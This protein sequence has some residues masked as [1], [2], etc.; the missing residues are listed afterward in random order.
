M[1]AA[2]TSPTTSTTKRAQLTL[3]WQI[4]RAGYRRRVAL[5]FCRLHFAQKTSAHPPTVV[6]TTCRYHSD[7]GVFQAQLLLFP[8]HL[9]LFHP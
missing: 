6:M 4:S 8:R 3:R 5:D 7:E 9:S 1:I 2:L